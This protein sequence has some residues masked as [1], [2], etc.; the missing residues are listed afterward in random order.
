M[1]YYQNP[2]LDTVENKEEYV[3]MFVASVLG[4]NTEEKYIQNKL[5]FTSGDL[6]QIAFGNRLGYLTLP[7]QLGHSCRS[8]P[9]LIYFNNKQTQC[10]LKL[11]DATNECRQQ[12]A[13]NQP[14][15]LSL[16]YFFNDFDILK[17]SK[18]VKTMSTVK[19]IL[20]N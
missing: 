2:L 11:S 5:S 8:G 7:A 10:T 3:N 6:V 16:Q 1:G 4:Q 13:N 17:V 19:N 20:L 12:N 14:S 18:L 9:P 15:T